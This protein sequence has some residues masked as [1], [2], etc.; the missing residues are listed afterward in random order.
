MRKHYP[1]RKSSESLAELFAMAKGIPN[2]KG[3]YF[4]YMRMSTNPS[5]NEFAQVKSTKKGHIPE[6]LPYFS[7]RLNGYSARI[8]NE[9][10]ERVSEKQ[11]NRKI[12]QADLAIQA[13]I[14][15][16]IL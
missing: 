10:W 6:N 14:N 16:R 9:N 8:G 15:K 2:V 11:L 1:H 7:K 13:E 5:D 12:E 3:A 4:T